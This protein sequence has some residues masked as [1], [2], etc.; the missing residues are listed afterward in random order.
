MKTIMIVDDEENMLKKTKS[1]LKN[2]DYE[3]VTASNNREALEHIDETR[4]GNV[5]LILV[6][7]IMP[8]DKK[9]AFFSM[10][11][12]SKMN[13]DTNNTEDFL[14]KPFT[15]EQLLSFVKDKL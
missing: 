1:F 15:K 4:G 10:K 3:V 13:L 7:T 2:D 12:A 9:P 8:S 6:G 5:N 11:P 14:Q